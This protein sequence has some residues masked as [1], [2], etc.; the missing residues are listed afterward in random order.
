MTVYFAGI[1]IC[2]WIGIE[3][4]RKN[5]LHE[6]GMMT[7]W[8]RSDRTR[9]IGRENVPRDGIR[10]DKFPDQF[11]RTSFVSSSMISL[12]F[13]TDGFLS[14]IFQIKTHFVLKGGR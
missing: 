7:N 10:L 4:N 13:I 8:N 12:I 5:D 2:L 1:L 9:S 6:I 3:Y 14:R 11:M